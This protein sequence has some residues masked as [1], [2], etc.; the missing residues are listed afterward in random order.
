MIIFGNGINPSTRELL[1]PPISQ[2]IFGMNVFDYAL[3]NQHEITNLLK[4]T[5]L[6]TSFKFGAPIILRRELTPIIDINDVDQMGWTFLVSSKDKHVS[7]I[8]DVL[9]PLAKHRKMTNPK[10]PL[11]FNGEMPNQ[12]S[13][14]FRDN[15]TSPLAEGK[16]VPR[17]VLIVGDP[18][19]IPFK[20]QS[21]L[22]SA[23]FVG[24]IDFDSREQITSYINKILRL[25]QN[26]STL[27][28]REVFAMG[29]DFGPSDPTF[30]SA[31]YLVKPISEYV[32]SKLHFK[33][34]TLL[35][36]QASKSNLMQSLKQ[37]K[38]ALV[39]TASHGA[40]FLNENFLTQKKL[41]GAIYCQGGEDMPLDDILFTSYD[42]PVDEGFLEGAIFFQFACF[43]YGTPSQSDFQH[44]QQGR[45]QISSQQGF[46]SDMPKTLLAHDRGPIAYIGHVDLAWLQGFDDPKNPD[47]LHGYD[48]RIVPFIDSCRSLLSAEPV[49]RSLEEM[50]KRYDIENA[51][52]VNRI[53]QAKKQ[54]E[55]SEKLY[56]SIAEEFIL[57][58]DAQNYML[59][60]DPAVK[61]N[62]TK[63]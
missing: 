7:D 41:N 10:V 12:W 14:W 33:T 20:F 31:K 29:T 44:W 59:L 13:D 22:D 3:Q 26:K 63:K 37:N 36:E 43:G 15:Y 60:G 8:I 2:E 23:G 4:S 55:F 21:L 6:T 61:I 52:I 45:V 46:V 18:D 58:S 19:L 54:S 62:V 5:Q 1:Y 35:G 50:N 49:G 27:A 30:Y 9:Q 40:G 56:T 38:P 48:N 11:F 57:R 32:S 34:K 42:I 25:E 51:V 39:F 17:Y 16:K 47:P 53:D 28:S 24:R